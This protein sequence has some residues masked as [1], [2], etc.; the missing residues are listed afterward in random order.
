L[1]IAAATVLSFVAFILVEKRSPRPMFDFSV[2][3]IRAFAGALF[4]AMG[5]NFSY[6]PF[7][8][9]LP[10]YFQGALGYTSVDAG[11]SLLAYTLP[12]LVV[13]PLAERLALRFEAR[14]VI[15]LGMFAIGLGFFLMRLGAG[16]EHASWL[17]MLPGCLLCG[18]GLG[19]TNTPVTNT[20]TG[21]VSPNRAG[22]ASGIDMSARLISLAINIALMGFILLEGVLADLTRAL[23]GFAETSSLRLL[24]EKVAAGNIAQLTQGSAE[25]AAVDPHGVIVHAALVHGFERVMLYGAIGAWALAVLSA[26][27][28]GPDTRAHRR[29]PALD[30]GGRHPSS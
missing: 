8:I 24:A 2:L 15:P 14:R 28:F 27:A 6:W 29:E 22:M 30:V 17:T 11:L 26:M 5:M 18:T 16:M 10:I 9:Y 19:L 4:G 1:S 13:P 23:S 20:A 25:L 7:M 21:S 3:R 12:T